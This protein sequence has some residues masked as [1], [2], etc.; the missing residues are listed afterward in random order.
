VRP[1]W[2]LRSHVPHAQ[3]ARN[4]RILVRVVKHRDPARKVQDAAVPLAPLDLCGRAH[5]DR[6]RG[7]VTAAHGENVLEHKHLTRGHR[8]L[9]AGGGSDA[10]RVGAGATS[11][12][13]AT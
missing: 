8:R 7:A 1:G 12:G 4:L 13:G 2:C 6:A 9:S 11:A 5:Q 3:I 10:M